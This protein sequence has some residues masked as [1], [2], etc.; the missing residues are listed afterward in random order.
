MNVDDNNR[1]WEVTLPVC[2]SEVNF[3]IDSGAD[4]NVMTLDSF[5][6]LVN[7]P[8]LI[9]SGKIVECRMST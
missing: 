4:V 9:P 1:P 5:E 3:K 6:N 7:K 8:T 2:G